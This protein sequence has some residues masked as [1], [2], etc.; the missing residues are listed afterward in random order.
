MGLSMRFNLRAP[1]SA[2]LELI[3]VARRGISAAFGLKVSGWR[4]LRLVSRR[5]TDIT[6]A[7]RRVASI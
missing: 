2:R 7:E 5:G 6:I 3:T 4:V 1:S